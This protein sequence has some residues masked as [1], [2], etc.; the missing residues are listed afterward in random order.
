MKNF[1]KPNS[2]QYPKKSFS[3]VKPFIYI[4]LAKDVTRNNALTHESIKANYLTGK[5]KL[6]IQVMSDYLF[7]GS[8]NYDF[9]KDDK[10]VYY[11]FF[12]SSNKLTIPGTSVKG[13]VRSVAEAI[14]NSC[15]SH[16][17]GRKKVGRNK[18]KDDEKKYFS[19]NDS[20]LACNN[21]IQ[22]CPTCSIFGT[23][24]Y[25]GKIGFLDASPLKNVKTEIVKI[26]E[27]FSPKI[28]KKQRKFYQNKKFNPIGNLIPE[29][30]HRFVEAVKKDSKF[31]TWM[32]FQNL[33]KNELSLI[34]YSMGIKQDYNIKIGGAKPR[35]FGT[36]EIQPL[37]IE[38]LNHNSL[39][40]H[41]NMYIKKD[42]N[43]INEILENK[44]LLNKEI[45]KSFRKSMKFINDWC[46]R[47]NY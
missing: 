2:K 45:F 21:Y 31:V 12:R 22:L 25:S 29:K 35:C 3:S 7:S 17:A 38:L 4:N 9:R 10:L 41:N 43:F 28:V 1:K 15:V 30:Q 8:G 14:S 42:L 36:V 37:E 23:T 47:G 5:I 19:R 39:F 20:R 33:S 34:L 44:D 24:D 18:Y 11:T 16:M 26:G 46:P 32:K 6:Q 40:S 13:S 27:L